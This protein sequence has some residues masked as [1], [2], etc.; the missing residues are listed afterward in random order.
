MQTNIKNNQFLL[1]YFG[2]T[3]VVL[4]A[5]AF[6]FLMHVQYV[7]FITYV[8]SAA[9]Y[10]SYCFVYLLPLFLVLGLLQSIIT[11]LLLAG[12]LRK[13]HISP[14]W[15]IYILAILLSTFLQ[16]L[17]S[18]DV[19]VFN[20]YGFHMNGFVWNLIITPGGIQSMGAD[21][22]TVVQFVIIAVGFF[23]VQ[24]TLL[25]LLVRVERF[26]KSCHTVFRK[27]RTR[28]FMANSEG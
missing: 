28:A 16:L 18:T 10:I 21:T 2:L 4:L 17:I 6:R 1:H 27:S 26:K 7:G 24:T 22:G 3:Y 5:N 20:I 23:L 8:F 15:T 9:A 14:I 12:V 19:F 13:V 25:V 11:S